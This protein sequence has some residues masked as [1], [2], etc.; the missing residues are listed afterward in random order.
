LKLL[1]LVTTDVKKNCKLHTRSVQRPLCTVNWA[2]IIKAVH[3][4]ARHQVF[5]KN[6]DEYRSKKTSFS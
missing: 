3:F 6:P 2:G 4:Q 5:K 1:P